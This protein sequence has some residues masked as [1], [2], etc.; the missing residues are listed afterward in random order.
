MCSGGRRGGGGGGGGCD[1]WI[2]DIP[3]DTYKELLFGE[4]DESMVNFF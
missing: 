4:I 1:G 2:W 3:P